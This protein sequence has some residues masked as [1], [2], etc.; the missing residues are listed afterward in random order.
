VNTAAPRY[1]TPR[2][3]ERA[4][5][6]E[7]A[8]KIARLLDVILMPWQLAAVELFTEQTEDGRLAFSD[9]ALLVPRQ[10]GKSTWTLVLLLLRALGVPGSKCFYAAQT[11]KDARAMLVDTWVPMLDRSPLRGSYTVRTANGSEAIRFRNGSTIALITSTSTKA[12]HGLVVDMAVI[13]E[14]FAQPDSRMETA[15]LPAMATRTNVGGG[16]QF[17]LVSTAGTPAASPYLLHRVEQG[18]QLAEA[19]VTTGAAYIEYSADDD[20]DPADRAT[21][22]SCNPALN[23][24]ITEE[25]IAAEHASLDVMDFRRSRL[26]Q[27]TVAQS[28]PVVPLALWAELV[29]HRSK[30]GPNLALAFDSAPDG[31]TS[32]VAVASTREDGL[33]HVELVARAPGT[34][35][36]A[37]EVTRL[38]D[39]HGPHV[40][41][42][43]G[44]GPHTN[45]LPEL[46][47]L[48]VE[49][50]ELGAGDAARAHSAFVSACNEKTL[51]HLDQ[52]EL[53]AALTAAVRRPLGDAYAWSR[54]S[55]ADDISPVVAATVASWA[56]LTVDPDANKITVLG[57][58]DFDAWATP[59]R[60]KDIFRRAR[61]R[62]QLRGPLDPPPRPLL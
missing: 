62:G 29:D 13:D 11:L 6:G 47:R 22:A 49:V 41:A 21:W 43:D 36:L 26:C 61:E 33:L 53:T 19:G 51:R 54:R 58:R 4:N 1:A 57:Q 15:L 55:S 44:R 2:T 37:A 25:A 38:V 8:Q 32:S 3:P 23:F 12:G 40:V 16:P 7:A 5:L 34:G 31:A 10:N 59:E 18:R 52:P 50:L 60:V 9:C 24:T 39:A 14:A 45:A 20:A 28:E 27:W 35:W 17:V 46:E 56:A 48:E 42:C 30:R